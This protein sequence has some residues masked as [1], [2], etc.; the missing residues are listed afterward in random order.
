MYLRSKGDERDGEAST[1][2]DK[3]KPLPVI[4]AALGVGVMTGF[5]GVGGGFLIV[6]ALVLFSKLP[7]KLAVGT[8]LLVIGIN[9]AAGFVGHLGQSELN[10]SLTIIFTIA[11]VGGAFVGERLARRI[12]AGSLMQ[13]FALCIVLVG[14]FLLVRNASALGV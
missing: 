2:D 8:S 9:S 11:A 3:G 4:M 10:L 6:P 5:L 14:I 1:E 13:T 7:M 12:S